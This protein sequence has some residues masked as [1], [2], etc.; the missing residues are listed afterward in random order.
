MEI[1]LFKDSSGNDI[2]NEIKSNG[3]L[4]NEANLTMYIDKDA[5]G[6]NDELIEPSRLY[7]YDIESKSPLIDYFIDNSQ[8]QKP[9]D[10]K[11]VHSGLIEI[12]ED[13]NGIKY[14]IRISEH[15]KNIIRNDSLNK[16]LGLVV[17]SDITNAIN[18][19]LKNNNQLEYIPINSVINPLGTILYGPSPEPVNNDKRL[20]LELFYTEINN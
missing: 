20:R 4:I 1:D 13:K 8:G 7:L 16:K 17:S 9:K 10:Q 18:T 15:V 6:L 14:K 3:W 2:L 19:E 12:D 5:I 11:I